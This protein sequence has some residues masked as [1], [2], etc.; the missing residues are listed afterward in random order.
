MRQIIPVNWQ[1]EHIRSGTDDADH[2]RDIGEPIVTFINETGNRLHVHPISDRLVRVVHKLPASLYSSLDLDDRHRHPTGR[3]GIAW[4]LVE[5][6]NSCQWTAEVG[7]T[8]EL[9]FILLTW[10]P[11]SM[12]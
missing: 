10:T 1:V 2:S 12:L 3:D 4:E 6:Y 8:R 9:R 7:T 11:S 5:G